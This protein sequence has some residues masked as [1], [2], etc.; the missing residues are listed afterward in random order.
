[1]IFQDLGLSMDHVVKV[2]AQLTDVSE[3]SAWNDVFLD[4]LEAPYPCPVGAPLVVGK[5]EVEIV[6][7]AVP[8]R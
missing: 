1:M 6:A 8:R 3:F 5:I 7:A 2:N 4:V